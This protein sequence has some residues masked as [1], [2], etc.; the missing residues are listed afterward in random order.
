MK[1]RQKTKEIWVLR[2]FIF[3]Q[4]IPLKNLMFFSLMNS[5]YMCLRT[6]TSVKSKMYWRLKYHNTTRS[7]GT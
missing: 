1:K 3:I 7:T 6:V 4:K 5:V 2:E